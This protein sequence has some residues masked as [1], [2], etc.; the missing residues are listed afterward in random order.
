MGYQ[1]EEILFQW[2]YWGVFDTILP[3]LLVFAI[4]F[5]ILSATKFMGENKGVYVIVAGVI[6]LI[7]I[8]YSY[9]YSDFISELFPR[10]GI[11]LAV[12]VGIMILVGMFV[13][14]DE[15]R[16]WGWGLAVIGLVIGIVILYQTFTNLGY[17][18]PGSWGSDITGIIILAILLIGVIVAVT[19]G[20]SK[21]K[22]ED[23]IAEFVSGWNKK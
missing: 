4:V 16:Y 14:K 3:F 6:G 22:K 1:I 11:G 21:R 17:L 13:A 12:L 15:T 5:G 20:D 8:R 2:E 19:S 7:S 23:G 18:Y 10:L 9:F